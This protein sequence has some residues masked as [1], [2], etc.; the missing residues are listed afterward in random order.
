MSVAAS[1]VRL[2]W[3]L[4]FW[5][6]S[7]LASDPSRAWLQLQVS[8]L[9]LVLHTLAASRCS[10]L[11][12]QFIPDIFQL[13]TPQ[14]PRLS[15]SALYFS[16]GYCLYC[17][18]QR[19]TVSNVYFMGYYLHC[20]FQRGG[21]YLHCIFQ[22][23]TSYIVSFKGVLPVLYLSN[24]HPSFRVLQP[25]PSDLQQWVTLQHIHHKVKL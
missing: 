4:L 11:I 24:T 6:K 9:L 19:G 8:C 12:F 23:G 5:L 22:R 7:S 2:G 16:K 20:I 1:V 10:A 3:M 17:I 15:V 25:W 14:C 13:E 18:F 21:Y